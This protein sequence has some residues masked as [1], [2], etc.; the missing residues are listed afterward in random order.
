MLIKG[1]RESCILLLALILMAGYVSAAE[2]YSFSLTVP[3]PVVTGIGIGPT[4]V[5]GDSAG[6]IYATNGDI[7]SIWK[8]LSGGKYVIQLGVGSNGTPGQFNNVGEI[9]VIANDYLYVFDWVNNWIQ[10]FFS[11]PPTASFT[12]SVVSPQTIQFTNSSISNVA[13][14]SYLWNFGDGT[15][16]MSASPSHTYLS[17]GVYNVTLT[18]TNPVGTSSVTSTVTAGSINLFPFDPNSPT[19]ILP[20]GG[21][22]SV[23]PGTNITVA[24]APGEFEDSSFIITNGA[25]ATFGINITPNPLTSSNG[26][27][28]PASAIDVKYVKVWYQAMDP[29]SETTGGQSVWYLYPELLLN[30]DGLV[31]VN[32]ILQQNF[33]YVTNGTWTG[34]KKVSNATDSL[35]PFDY[36]FEDSPTLQPLS[37]DAN[38][39]RQIWVTVHI[40]DRQAPGSYLGNIAI[41]NT[42]GYLGNMTLNVT[43]LNFNL[44]P[45]PLIYGLYYVGQLISSP[46]NDTQYDG[47]K[48]NITYSADLADL[49]NHGILYP[50]LYQVSTDPL[51]RTALQLRKQAGLPTDKLFTVN[52][53]A[54]DVDNATI[55]SQITKLKTE[56]LLAASQGFGK[57]YSYGMDEAEQPTLQ[58]E[59][60]SAGMYQ[61]NGSGTWVAVSSGVDAYNVL[62]STL[63]YSVIAGQSNALGNP[64]AIFNT[65]QA[66]QWQ[67]VGGK[68]AEYGNPQ[69]GVE[70]A[71]IYRA[72]YGFKLWNAGFN[73]SF[74]W[75]Y[76][77]GHG[78]FAWND[79]DSTARSGYLAEDL[80][81]PT[82]TG[83]VDTI[84]YEGLR[85]G[86]DDT[87]YI[88]T[89]ISVD[90][91]NTTISNSIVSSGLTANQLPETIRSTIINQILNDEKNYS[92]LH[93]PPSN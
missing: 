77:Y 30:N 80:T 35:A 79:W 60:A 10:K 58:A 73:G 49:Q 88:A 72:N 29:T 21:M 18:V 19:R 56:Q 55:N 45:S 61:S 6:L 51:F 4:S 83:V 25:S 22:P 27:T 63:N 12:Q 37:L 84:E 44:Q 91:G 17:A 41:T 66:T 93:I 52:N 71:S 7:Y 65:T 48:T 36:T 78:G 89:L 5:A 9:G 24:A 42:S 68:A 57:I 38:E 43:V 33:L 69:G 47:Y 75:G 2:T 85:E 74:D 23:P 81:Y 82:T 31:S 28:I 11:P 32:Y 54:W 50:T 3:N 70:N 46:V 15:T 13:D 59:K 87:R 76:Q 53:V 92:S 1:Y 40:P 86:I 34:Y 62:G 67:S 8:F 64:P 16:S 26:G 14:T 20:F 90:G 39:N